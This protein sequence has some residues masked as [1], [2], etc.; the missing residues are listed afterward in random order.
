MKIE[1]FGTGCR[2]CKR[3]EKDVETAVKELGIAADIEKVRDINKIASRGVMMTPAL[4]VDG[5]I[6][7]SGKM[8][9]LEDIKKLLG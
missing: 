5:E 7:T 6:K 8:L 2:K 3:L 4:A 1:I 9:S